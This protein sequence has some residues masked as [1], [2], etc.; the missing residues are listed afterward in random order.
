MPIQENPEAVTIQSTSVIQEVIQNAKANPV[1]AI[2]EFIKEV[3]TIEEANKLIDQG[4]EIKKMFREKIV[5]FKQPRHQST[6]EVEEAKK[7][8]VPKP[9]IVTDAFIAEM[10]W[11]RTSPPV[12]LKYCFN[13]DKFEKVPKISLG[14]V[15]SEGREI[16]YVPPFDDTLKKGIVIVPTDATETTFREAINEIDSFA[17]LCYD[18]CGQDALVKLLTRVSVGS[19][20]LD[21]FKDGITIDIAGS[22]KFAPILPI[23]GPSSSGKNRLAFVLRLISYRPYFEMSTVRI[24]SL[25]RPLDIW[26]GTLILDEADFANTNEKS[27]IIHY[28]NCRATGSP[29]TRQN[30][31]DPSITDAFD[32]FGLTIVTQRKSFDD[33]ATESR[34]IPFYSQSTD[35]K[36]SVLETEVM[37]EKGLVLQNK[38]LYL[39]MKYYKQVVINKEKRI[40]GISDG[41]LIASLLPLVA[42]SELEPAVAITIEETAKAVEKAKV[43]EKSTSMDGQLIN[44]IWDKV[45]DRLFENHRPNL[46][47]LLENITVEE[48]EKHELEHRQALTTKI[49]ADH[50]K[51]WSSTSIRKTLDSLVI[52]QKG[53]PNLIRVDNSKAR[54]IFFDPS[55]L[56]KRL[57]EFV[58]DYKA[59]T[60]GTLVTPSNVGE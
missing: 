2:P 20:F 31:K 14:E 4:Y 29:V 23:R 54:V 11:D 55:L 52:A 10:I 56:E 22:G 8:Y 34:G 51:S 41:R 50:F 24:P 6:V 12:Y 15:D 42:L 38:L 46:Y 48:K 7:T 35:K 32:N 18:A 26:R 16:I 59:G 47:Y 19:W 5:L 28:L 36:M 49:L 44:Y 39:R 13:E 33:N 17:I 27:E 9:T 3:A 1:P 40:N 30:P 21:R 45:E 57:R 43:I 60:L 53:I 37:I 25:F 58:I